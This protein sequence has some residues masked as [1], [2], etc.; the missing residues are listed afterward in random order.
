MKET[1]MKFIADCFNRVAGMVEDVDGLDRLA[2]EVREFCA[3]YP[4]P[5]IISR[6]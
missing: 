6:H 2:A 1:E 5:G 4:A 3:A